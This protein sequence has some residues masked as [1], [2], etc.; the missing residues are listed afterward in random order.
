M[1]HGDALL[2]ASATEPLLSELEH[3]DRLHRELL[4]LCEEER[5]SLLEEPADIIKNLEILMALR[6]ASESDQQPSRSSGSKSRSNLKRRTDNNDIGSSMDSPGPSGEKLHRFKGNSQRSGSVGGSQ[7]RD[8]VA[9]KVEE[10]VE[11]NKGQLAER[12]G[13]LVVGAEVMYRHPKKAIPVEGE[14]IQC[15][16]K[17]ITGDGMKKK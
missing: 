7:P 11:V 9:I 12:T 13:Q 14:G 8:I 17:M 10:G 2:I 15:I 6:Q 3:L 4:K 1:L 5:N 16:I